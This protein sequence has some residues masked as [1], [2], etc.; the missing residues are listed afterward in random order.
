[1]SNMLPVSSE[2][3]LPTVA[4]NSELFPLPSKHSISSSSMIL[5]NA[6]YDLFLSTFRL[7]QT[8]EWEGINREE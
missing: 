2:T 8:S 1:M 5:R 6:L 4:L 7:V 3:A